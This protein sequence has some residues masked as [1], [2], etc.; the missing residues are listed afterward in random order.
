MKRLIYGLG[1]VISVV[2]LGLLLAPAFLEPDQYR[3]LIEDQVEDALGRQV[4][5]EGELSLSLL[6]SPSLSAE[7]VRIANIPG[8]STVDFVKIGALEIDVAIGPLLRG[9]VQVERTVLVEPVVNLEVLQSGGNNWTITS[10]ATPANA[11][12]DPSGFDVSL[13]DLLI[14]NG[15]INYV[16]GSTGTTHQFSQVNAQLAA[17][18]MAGPFRVDGEL[19]WNDLKASINASLGDTGR[20]RFPV[21][22]KLQLNDYDL[23]I[24]LNGVGFA[25]DAHH[26]FDGKVRAQ[27]DDLRHLLAELMGVEDTPAGEAVLLAV[28]GRASLTQEAFTLEDV[29][30]TLG[31]VSGR[32]ELGV[33][34]G[35]V[36]DVRAIVSLPVLDTEAL[37]MRDWFD[38]VEPADDDAPFAIPS[39]MAASLDLTIEGIRL[40]EQTIR[41]IRLA[42]RLENEQVEITNFRALLPGSSD[43][44]LG[45]VVKARSGEPAFEGQF[46]IG[47]SNFH[48]LL[49]SMGVPVADIPKNRLTQLIGSGTLSATGS[50]MRLADLALKVDSTNLTGGLAYGFGR[51][52]PSLGFSLSADRLNADA[53]MPVPAEDEAEETDWNAF[54]ETLSDYDLN[55]TLGFDQLTY[56]RETIRQLA[57]DLRVAADGLTINSLTSPDLAGAG[58]EAKNLAVR[59][60]EALG[61]AGNVGV[62]SND[63]NRLLRLAGYSELTQTLRLSS[64][65]VDLTVDMQGDQLDLRGTGVVGT[66]QTTMRIQSSNLGAPSATMTVQLDMQNDSWRSLSQMAGLDVISPA[67][68]ADVPVSARATLEAT[69]QIYQMN[70]GLSLG[71]AQLG[72]TGEANLASDGAVYDLMTQ[73][74]ASDALGAMASIGVAFDAPSLKGQPLN[75][76]AMIKG[77][78]NQLQLQALEGRIG[79]TAFNGTAILDAASEVAAVQATLDFGT[80]D[81]G[82]FLGPQETGAKAAKRNG[83]LRWSDDPIDLSWLDGLKADVTLS[84]DEL[85]FH[86]YIFTKPRITLSAGQQGITVSDMKAGLFGGALSLKGG[87]LRGGEKLELTT[88]FQM[89]RTSVAQLLAAAADLTVATGNLTVGGTISGHGNSQKEI[90]SSLDGS[91]NMLA[92]NGVVQGID[93]VRI[94]ETMLTLV[95]Y[96]DFISLVRTAMN[97]GETRYERIEAPFTIKNGVAKTGPV[98]AVLEASEA[99]VSA[100]IDLPRWKL[101]TDVDFRLTDPGHEQTPSVGLRLTGAIDN[102]KRQ[103]RAKEM[104]AFIGRRLANRLLEDFGGERSSGLRQLLGGTTDPQTTDQP[105]GQQGSTIGAPPPGQSDGQ[106][107]QGQTTQGQQP[108]QQQEQQTQDPLGLLLRGILNEVTKDKETQN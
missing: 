21:E 84:A 76:S 77:P 11:P 24:D 23:D 17:D 20:S 103:T 80:F 41:Q 101:D 72:V 4:T 82:A 19:Q 7:G 38:S 97:G 27:A 28:D 57:V 94:S 46:R 70:I 108:E 10:K 13:D 9:V 25:G 62:I 71:Q 78:A 18:T 64:G 8:A 61:V 30:I 92:I 55:G 40:E 79:K 22:A 43:I 91:V 33:N 45:G 65:Q 75:L 95:E 106:T 73:L 96:D 68:A 1:A 48:A 14:E 104:T 16:D 31:H 5:I 2:V 53:Y 44:S 26:I 15:T 42:A 74:E 49:T 98:T 34:Y 100:T 6:P 56:Q 85:L 3:D 90:V 87:L 69:G 107:T 66:T 59:H 52:R 63:L 93:M 37:A 83:R 88:E 12:S 54:I 51:E 47:S 50:V 58:V 102:P 67:Q 89:Q 81:L 39:D 35:D 105:S 60:G 99:S 29:D 32:A 86:Q 36:S